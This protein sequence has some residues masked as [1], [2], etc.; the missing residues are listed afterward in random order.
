MWL[1]FSLQLYLWRDGVS[2]SVRESCVIGGG[3]LERVWQA[4]QSKEKRWAIFLLH[5]WK[6]I[7]QTPLANAHETD[8]TQLWQFPH[9]LPLTPLDLPFLHIMPP[10]SV[11]LLH[12]WIKSSISLSFSSVF[13]LSF[14]THLGKLD[15]RTPVSQY[16]EIAVKWFIWLTFTTC[17]LFCASEC[18]CKRELKSR[19]GV[20]ACKFL[21]LISQLA[22]NQGSKV[23]LAQQLW[24]DKHLFL[25]W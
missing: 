16:W 4:L 2:L 6:S 14:T 1:Y 9:L 15:C 17:M 7:T 5:A 3:L 25:C 13:L 24:Q 19:M 12:C 21:V 10:N 11:L 8:P 18:V 23:G 22:L 20:E